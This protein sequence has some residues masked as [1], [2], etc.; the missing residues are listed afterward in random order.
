MPG[1]SAIF[2]ALSYLIDTIEVYQ[3][4]FTPKKVLGCLQDVE[5]NL[6]RVTQYL[7]L[8]DRGV[9]LDRNLQRSTMNIFAACLTLC[10]LYSKVAEDSNHAI[11]LFK[12]IMKAAIRWDDGL[13]AHLQG[14]KR[15][16]EQEISNNIAAIRISDIY[17]N[18]K[19]TRDQHLERLKNYLRPDNKETHWTGT[20]ETL[21]GK[22]IP[23]IGDW[24]FD[25]VDVK[26]WTNH[27][28]HADSVVL[29]I[30]TEKGKGKTH[31]CS[32]IIHSL[33]DS[34]ETQQHKESASVGWYFFPGNQKEL[35]KKSPKARNESQGVP[36]HDALKAVVWQLVQK[37]RVFRY[38]VVEVMNS[39]AQAFSD[40]NEM[41]TA[42]FSNFSQKSKDDPKGKPGKVFYLVLDGFGKL[43][44]DEEKLV[45]KMVEDTKRNG[46]RHVQFRLLLSGTEK[47]SCG[48][49]KIEPGGTDYVSDAELFI[50]KRA[51]NQWHTTDQ[52]YR[53]FKTILRKL[54]KNFRG[55]FHELEKCLQEVN[56]SNWADLKTI[57]EEGEGNMSRLII[58]H[59]LEEMKSKLDADE[60]AILKE[61][62]LCIAFWCLWPSLRQLDA[63][64]SIQLQGRY[65]GDIGI[66]LS[67]NFAGLF[68][69]ED[70]MVF[71]RPLLDCVEE[72][73]VWVK[74]E[75]LIHFD[76]DE[77]SML[78]THFLLKS[79]CEDTCRNLL[80]ARC[81][82]E[83]TA[84]YLPHHFHFNP[85]ETVD[86]IGTLNSS[87]Q[88]KLGEWLFQALMDQEIVSVWLPKG[89]IDDILAEKEWVEEISD[90]GIFWHHKRV[91]K[92]FFQR[93][94]WS[95]EHPFLT[96]YKTL[97]DDLDDLDIEAPE[98]ELAM[99]RMVEPHWLL[100]ASAKVV[101]SQWLQKSKWDALP[102]LK[103][104]LKIFR[105][106][107]KL[108]SALK[109]K[110][111]DCN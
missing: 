78:T 34:C 13:S 40:P 56:Q 33:T 89:D 46:S 84:V 86:A 79:I 68:S 12:N 16:T 108:E 20:Q 3:K 80:D 18:D 53:M 73:Q 6:S 54:E 5:D 74:E 102:A 93:A 27:K 64:L 36:I 98:W 75:S 72:K 101:A 87:Q 23:G 61:L 14:M 110:M 99:P 1:G 109:K 7:N 103:F 62:V 92:G 85:E 41:W 49:C 104:L 31:L 43:D 96:R 21:C 90:I 48:G 71:A 88:E 51:L 22:H 67:E 26:S 28:C 32:Q 39:N 59:H 58:Q 19:H 63:Y 60:I 107:C 37:D 30:K 70:G 65:K 57:E 17:T 91:Q 9:K 55:D 97:V 15:G 44:E 94:K 95:A 69:V 83:Y 2:T 76:V 24:V 100:E 66:K 82:F 29:C 8:E 111:T 42:V 11:G 35:K 81:I 45:K 47:F 38:F 25:L 105:T 50:E 77:G 10:R 106:V 52:E 4:N